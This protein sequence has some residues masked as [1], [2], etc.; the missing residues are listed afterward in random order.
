MELL[1]PSTDRPRSSL[2]EMV[3]YSE[4]P[5]HPIHAALFNNYDGTMTLVVCARTPEEIGS[6]F[7]VSLA[8]DGQPFARTACIT[9]RPGRSG[10]SP[11]DRI[12]FDDLGENFTGIHFEAARSAPGHAVN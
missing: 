3:L 5:F 7:W 10:N 8:R 4:H 12:T 9:L 2:S 6:S 1:L 11:T